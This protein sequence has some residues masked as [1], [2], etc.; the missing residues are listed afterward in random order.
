MKYK[1][2]ENLTKL[3]T[4]RDRLNEE[5]VSKDIERR[6]LEDERHKLSQIAHVSESEILANTISEK[7]RND[8]VKQ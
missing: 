2:R 1:W 8:Y 5:L 6:N 7:L 3:E 4:E